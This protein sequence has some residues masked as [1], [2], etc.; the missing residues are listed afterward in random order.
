MIGV[1]TMEKLFG[2]SLLEEGKGGVVGFLQLIS[3]Q[4][5]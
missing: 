4:T 1:V 3:K 2:S 5:N